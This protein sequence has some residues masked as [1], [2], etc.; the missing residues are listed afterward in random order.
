[1]GKG[2]EQELEESHFKTCFT[3]PKSLIL[4]NNSHHSYE[5]VKYTKKCVIYKITSFT[6]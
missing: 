3:S 6:K 2:H 4:L 5:C 1:M